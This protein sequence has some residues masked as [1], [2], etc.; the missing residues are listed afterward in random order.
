MAAARRGKHS[1]GHAEW[2]LGDIW[3]GM[4][5]AVQQLRRGWREKARLSLGL[6]L[7]HHVEGEVKGAAR[8]AQGKARLEH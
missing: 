3:V 5:R 8:V 4:P 7:C 2:A 6:G 1:L